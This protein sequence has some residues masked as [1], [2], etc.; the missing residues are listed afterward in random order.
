MNINN[1][2]LFRFEEKI[3]N[4]T[5]YIFD[6]NKQKIYKGGRKEYDL[7]QNIKSGTIGNITKDDKRYEF[8]NWL[9]EK[10][11]LGA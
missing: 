11:I 1:G 4:G 6:M 9:L 8:I 2:I 10:E 3:G 7:I 5:L